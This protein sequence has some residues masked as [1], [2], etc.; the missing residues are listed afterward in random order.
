MKD[1]TKYIESLLD[2]LERPYE[3]KYVDEVYCVNIIF[4]HQDNINLGGIMRLAWIF[5]ANKT[6]SLLKTYLPETMFKVGSKHINVPIE[7]N[8]EYQHN[9]LLVPHNSGE[10]ILGESN[11]VVDYGSRLGNN[12]GSLYNV[13]DYGS[14]LYNTDPL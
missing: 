13:V 11:Y 3:V 7:L 5:S 12:F 8:R 4:D 10:D 2:G 9:N 1:L 6:E 14:F